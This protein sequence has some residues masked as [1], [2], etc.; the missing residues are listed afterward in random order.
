MSQSDIAATVHC[1]KRDVAAASKLIKAKNPTVAAVQAMTDSEAE[2]LLAPERKPRVKNP[3]YLQPDVDL[4]VERKLKRRKL[5]IKLM[6]FEYCEQAK[7][8]GKLAYSYQTFC[9]QFSNVL[10]KSS[11]TTRFLHD[12]AEK[13]YIDW[14]SDV[15]VLSDRLTGKSAKAYLSVIC[16]PCLD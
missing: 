3:D 14:A 12:P 9:E 8:Q 7:Q 16:L 6:W 1:S 13:A 2:E 15:F 11:A 4:L 5:P 10:A